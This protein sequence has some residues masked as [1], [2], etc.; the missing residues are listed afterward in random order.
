MSTT[1]TARDRFVYDPVEHP[2]LFS[3]VYPKRVVAFCIDIVLITLLMIPV[4]VMLLILG[5][6]TLGLG[7][8]LL[9]PLVPLVGLAYFAFTLGGGRS[10][11]PGMAFTGVEMRT[12][13]G[14]K[15]FPVLA[16]MHALLF[17]FSIALL[18]PLILL[19][20]LFT[21]R[22]QLLHDLLLGVV[23]LNT[24]GLRRHVSAR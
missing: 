10:A 5:I 12:W 8:L 11:T 17:Y 24:E 9:A 21:Y 20:G 6:V 1:R 23:I 14:G 16:A 18:T 7:W 4:T 2:E 15:A 22:K 19:V 13:S 3:D